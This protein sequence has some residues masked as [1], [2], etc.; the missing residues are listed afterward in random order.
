[1]V[2]AEAAEA[3]RSGRG[4]KKYF[5]PQRV[6]MLHNIVQVQGCNRTPLHSLI[7]LFPFCLFRS[8]WARIQFEPHLLVVL[9]YVQRLMVFS[10]LCVR[11]NEPSALLHFVLWLRET[12]PLFHVTTLLFIRDR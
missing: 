4:N 6:S 9:P 2:K 12:R 7:S 3:G 1:M 8:Y 5:L 11:V 10:T